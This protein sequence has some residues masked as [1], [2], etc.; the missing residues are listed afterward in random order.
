MF[1]KKWKQIQLIVSFVDVVLYQ[2]FRDSN[3]VH[4]LL[5]LES[6]IITLSWQFW[7]KQ[8]L[9]SFLFFHNFFMML[10]NWGE[11][12]TYLWR[13]YK[14]VIW[15]TYR[16]DNEKNPP[17]AAKVTT[18]VK[19]FNDEKGMLWDWSLW[20]WFFK[21]PLHTHSCLCVSFSKTAFVELKY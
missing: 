19:F 13:S 3:I 6:Q 4:P 5:G 15:T 10:K 18:L 20:Y 7:K 14:I 9:W 21:P 12:L 17:E 8:F 16:L 1:N 2:D 11:N